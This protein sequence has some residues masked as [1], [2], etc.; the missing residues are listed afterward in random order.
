M[1]VNTQNN[2]PIFLQALTRTCTEGH[3]VIECK[4]DRTGFSSLERST[5]KCPTCKRGER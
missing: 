1:L 3:T 5:V 2:F 4:S